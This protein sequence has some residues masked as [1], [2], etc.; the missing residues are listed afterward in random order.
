MTIEEQYGYRSAKRSKTRFDGI[1]LGK[2][3]KARALE[4]IVVACPTMITE[5]TVDVRILKKMNYS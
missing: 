3:N 4:S 2:S 1:D 5:P